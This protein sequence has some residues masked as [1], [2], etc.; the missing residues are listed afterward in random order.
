MEVDASVNH[1]VASI[2]N[3]R[4]SKRVSGASFIKGTPSS[5]KGKEMPTPVNVNL[6]PIEDKLKEHTDE[7]AK[8][9]E[10]ML[11]L[12]QKL[13]IISE[14]KLEVGK[15]VPKIKKKMKIIFD[16]REKA[17][18]DLLNSIWRSS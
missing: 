3:S 5:Q 4:Q 2:N 18:A 11:K 1:S 9:K 10:L 7:L 8:L 13:K 15:D 12:S 14:W 6:A 17:E 16:E